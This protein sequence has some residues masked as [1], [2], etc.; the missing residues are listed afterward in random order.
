MCFYSSEPPFCGNQWETQSDR[1]DPDAPGERDTDFIQFKLKWQ[2]K[3]KSSVRFTQ[4]CFWRIQ[5]GNVWRRTSTRHTRGKTRQLFLTVSEWIF[6]HYRPIVYSF[7]MSC[8][9]FWADQSWSVDPG[10]DLHQYD[11]EHSPQ[12][13]VH[14]T[15]H[16]CF[17]YSFEAFVLCN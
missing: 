13:Q 1:N 6:S 4:H 15:P 10:V 8:I 14:W 2:K 5:R 3:Q 12:P 17:V 11:S 16:L 7:R 9:G